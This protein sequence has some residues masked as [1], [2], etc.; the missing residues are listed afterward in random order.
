MNNNRIMNNRLEYEGK[1]MEEAR[2]L[3]TKIMKEQTKVATVHEDRNECTDFWI[4]SKRVAYRTRN[5][6]KYF[7]R[8]G[9]Q[10]SI[11]YKQINNAH[12]EYFKMKEGKA[13]DYMLYAWVE[14]NKI[15]KW[16][17]IDLKKFC[18]IHF[19][20]DAMKQKADKKIWYEDPKYNPIDGSMGMFFNLI[21]D[22][23]IK[24]NFYGKECNV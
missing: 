13:P 8:Y 6:G 16:V 22:I 24:S 5:M 15:A 4:G 14:G 10:F 19:Q 12:T 9:H 17:L 23:V 2:T 21:D 7:D 11:R 1:T 18:Q 3:M 20:E